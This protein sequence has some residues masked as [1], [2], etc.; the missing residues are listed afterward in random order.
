MSNKYL[1]AGSNTY[2]IHIHT[3]THTGHSN[4]Y[5]HHPITLHYR[6]PS[7]PFNPFTIFSPDSHLF[8]QRSSTATT[9]AAATHH[10]VFILIWQFLHPN[11]LAYISRADTNTVGRLS[12]VD[13]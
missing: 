7:H 10:H 8:C 4:T 11:L 3:R 5:V 6:Q 9:A 13:S 1:S 2:N 12:D